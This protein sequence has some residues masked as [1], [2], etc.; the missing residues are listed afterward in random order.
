M[1]GNI[2]VVP[3]PA[4]DIDVAPFRIDYSY[5]REALIEVMLLPKAKAKIRATDFYLSAR[6][7]GKGSNAHW[8]VTSWVPHV[9]PMVP[10]G[11]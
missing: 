9:S 7:V 1:T 11:Q 2:A 8:V 5:A 4:D 6:K 3:Y 10:I